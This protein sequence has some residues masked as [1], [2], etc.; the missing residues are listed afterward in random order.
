MSTHA[1]GCPCIRPPSDPVAR[2][3]GAPWL[4]V[5]F[6]RLPSLPAA[7]RCGALGQERESQT[8]LDGI[9]ARGAGGGQRGAGARPPGLRPREQRAG[10]G[11]A[12]PGGRRAPLRSPLDRRVPTAVP[13]PWG[14]ALPSQRSRCPSAPPPLLTRRPNSEVF[15]PRGR[16]RSPPCARAAPAAPGTQDARSGQ[17]MLLGPRSLPGP[18]RVPLARPRALR[19]PPP[20]PPRIASPRGPRGNRLQLVAAL[21]AGKDP[22]P[23]RLGLGVGDVSRRAPHASNSTRVAY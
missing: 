18:R 17:G 20:A 13:W 1:R 4:R 21:G 9:A 5:L 16:S 8:G 14:S 2:Q 10:V 19:C 12:P 22:P 15:S 11:A 6:I 3:L 23:V 7:L